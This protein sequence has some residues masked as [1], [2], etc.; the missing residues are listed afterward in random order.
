MHEWPAGALTATGRIGRL[1]GASTSGTTGGSTAGGMTGVPMS[2]SLV[3]DRPSLDDWSL[4][5]G[6]EVV[7]GTSIA[8]GYSM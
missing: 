7:A 5:G 1:W 3:L 8:A 6:L 4:S 2:Y